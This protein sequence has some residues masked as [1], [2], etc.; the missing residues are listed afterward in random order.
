MNSEPANP[1][2]ETLIS[3]LFG[4]FGFEYWDLFRILDLELKFSA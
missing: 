3:K 4:K 2:L 1:K